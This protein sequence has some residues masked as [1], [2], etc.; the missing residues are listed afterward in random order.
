MHHYTNITF[1]EL[2]SQAVSATQSIKT[3]T[4]HLSASARNS[5]ELIK[6][7]QQYRHTKGWIVLVAPSVKP[8]KVFWAGR[9]L[10]LNRILVVYQQQIKDLTI[11]LKQAIYNKSCN[12]V[13]NCAPLNDA[14]LT[15]LTDIASK[16]QKHFYTLHKVM[17]AAH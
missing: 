14:E 5:A 12:V 13:I 11:A 4:Q 17:K 16:Q 15:Y 9:H 8:N 7:L 10:P 6:L 2:M 1:P 3:E